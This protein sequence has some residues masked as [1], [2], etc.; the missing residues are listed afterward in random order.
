M[1]AKELGI[2]AL[3]IAGSVGPDARRI[4]DSGVD[5]YLWALQEPVLEGSL[6]E[7][8]PAMLEDCAEQVGR[9]LALPV[10]RPAALARRSS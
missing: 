1:V 5:A 6:A 2:P 8:G 7:R 3:L 10:V 9:L 4:L